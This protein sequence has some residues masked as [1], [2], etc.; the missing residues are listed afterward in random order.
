MFENNLAKLPIPKLRLHNSAAFCLR[1]ILLCHIVEVLKVSNNK[2]VTET[3]KYGS[4]DEP[5]TP[6]LVA[7]LH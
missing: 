6:S 4:R 1:Q 2:L 3:R 7:S 5:E